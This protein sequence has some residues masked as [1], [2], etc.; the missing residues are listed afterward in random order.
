[1]YPRLLINY[2]ASTQ[3]DKGDVDGAIET[4]RYLIAAQDSLDNAFSANQLQ[5]VKEIYHIDELLLEKQK[6]KDTNYK[7][8]F[9][10]LMTLLVLMLLF[11]VPE[12]S[13]GG[14]SNS[15]CGDAGRSG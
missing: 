7:Q 14:E 9:L 5:Q 4:R 15:G 11:Y 8:G 6:I 10:F 3:I 2:K 12:N 1:M 13:C